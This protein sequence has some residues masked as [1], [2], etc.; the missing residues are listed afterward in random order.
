MT[1]SSESEEEQSPEQQPVHQYAQSM[2]VNTT[3][4]SSSDFNSQVNVL[5]PFIHNQMPIKIEEEIS[6]P[7]N[8]NLKSSSHLSSSYNS[9][10]YSPGTS[11]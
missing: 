1:E 4:N 3:Q 8:S 7:N 6:Q 2:Y 10:D 5:K 9:S 11:T